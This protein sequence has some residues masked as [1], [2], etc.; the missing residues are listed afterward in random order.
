MRRDSPQFMDGFRRGYAQA[1]SDV[2]MAG[3]DAMHGTEALQA[4]ATA[5]G[6]DPAAS[7]ERW[8]AEDD[9]SIP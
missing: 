4:M 5:I 9:G 1:L 2:L 6:E 7:A 3:A 8:V